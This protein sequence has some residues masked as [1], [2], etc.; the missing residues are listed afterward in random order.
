MWTRGETGTFRPAH[1]WP[2]NVCLCWGGWWSCEENIWICFSWCAVVA[3]TAQRGQ[4]VGFIFSRYTASQLSA[5][6]RLRQIGTWTL[7]PSELSAMSQQMEGKQAGFLFLVLHWHIFLELR[8]FFFYFGGQRRAAVLRKWWGIFRTQN[9]TVLRNRVEK[10]NH[11]IDM[12][13]SFQWVMA[14]VQFTKLER[15][16]GWLF[17]I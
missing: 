6:S 17:G 2:I 1:V 12:Y 14:Q 8:P 11:G 3:A 13:K 4:W 10:K 7:L 5:S 16:S 15:M 9:T